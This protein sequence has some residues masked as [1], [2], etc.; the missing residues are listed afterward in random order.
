[1]NSPNKPFT[2][3]V[4]KQQLFAFRLASESLGGRMIRNVAAAVTVVRK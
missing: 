4:T 1:M 2:L 3:Y